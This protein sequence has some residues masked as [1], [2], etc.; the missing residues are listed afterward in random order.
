MRIHALVLALTLAALP[1]TSQETSVLVARDEQGAAEAWLS[2]GSDL[3]VTRPEDGGSG[4]FLERGSFPRFAP[5]GRVLYTETL[6]DG[7]EILSSRTMVLDPGTRSPRPLRR[8]E[9]ELEYRRP[10]LSPGDTTAVRV[11]IDP[12]HGG[13][14]PGAIGFGLQEKD[15][16]LDIALRLRHLLRLDTWNTKG[17]GSWDVLMTRDDDVYVGLSQRANLANAFGAQSFLSIHVNS[18]SSSS[19]NGTETY[20]YL[21]QSLNAGGMLRNAVHEEAIR[22]WGLRN[23]GVKEAN[24]AVLRLT[25]MPAA[26]AETGF[27]TSP[28]DIVKL[29]DPEARA[30]MALGYLF[31]LQLHHGFQMFDPR[32]SGGFLGLAR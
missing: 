28:I 2:P 13:T 29:Q 19:A 20:C 16:T 15:I 5:D 27:I 7:H 22:A 18:F 26:L 6:D 24:F 4:V 12:G 31:A 30:E 14:D 32:P 11:C 3:L 1:A 25:A 10:P 21:G 9:R 8:G 23:R 17:G